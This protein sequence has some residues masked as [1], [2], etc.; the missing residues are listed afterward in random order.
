MVGHRSFFCTG[1]LLAAIVSVVLVA[2]LPGGGGGTGAPQASR[3]PVGRLQQRLE[4]AISDQDF[5]AVRAAIKAGAR[6]REPLPSGN[7]PLIRA[8]A[9]Q[10]VSI[11]RLLLANGADPNALDPLSSTTPL[12]AAAYATQRA[13]VDELLKAG[14]DPNKRCGPGQLLSPLSEAAHATASAGMGA[15]IHAGADVNAWNPEPP[16]DYPEGYRGRA[17]GRTA[18]MIAAD[19][20]NDIAV[21][22]LLDGGAD[23]SLKN[24]K[25]QTALDL[26]HDSGADIR[27]ALSHPERFQ[28]LRKRR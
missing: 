9:L 21:L 12:V 22:G 5:D 28:Y 3:R 18:L 6:V 17:E 7:S 20:G 2:Q 19:A 11:V 27:D 16:D 23:P 24:E 26:I 8:A 1:V 4:A 13:L 10:N 14:A 25:G 15:L